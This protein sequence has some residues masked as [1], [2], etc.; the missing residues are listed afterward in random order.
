MSWIDPLRY[1]IATKQAMATSPRIKP[2]SAKPW[3]DASG[4]MSDVLDSASD[5]AEYGL[6]LSAEENHRTHADDGDQTEDETVFCQAL[7]G[8]VGEN[9]S[10][11][12][13]H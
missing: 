11:G 9:G 8:V 7:S 13:K 10:E 5:I 1:R 12:C 3:P 6:D 2:Y 4:C